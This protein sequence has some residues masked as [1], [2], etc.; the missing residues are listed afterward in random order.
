M[1]KAKQLH[2]NQMSQPN[3]IIGERDI[4][5]VYDSIIIRERTL[6]LVDQRTLAFNYN[7]LSTARF[8]YLNKFPLFH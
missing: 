4:T 6:L 5:P 3:V 1:V 8:L 2:S 7:Q